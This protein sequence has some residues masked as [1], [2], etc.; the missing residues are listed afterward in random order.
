M[1]LRLIQGEPD[2]KKR[3]EATRERRSSAPVV[4]WLFETAREVT[5]ERQRRGLAELIERAQAD[6]PEAG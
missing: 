4:F 6:E 1:A 5:C 3:A 2:A